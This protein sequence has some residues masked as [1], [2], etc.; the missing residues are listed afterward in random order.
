M[1]EGRRRFTARRNERG[2]AT[3]ELALV[4]PLAVLL[5]LVVV[6][7]GVIAVDLVLVHHAAREAARAAA[8]EPTTS[9]AREAAVGSSS[10]D[11]DRIVVEL[12]GGSETGDQTTATVVYRASTSVPLV[13]PLIPD[14]TLRASVTMRV[15]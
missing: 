5:A 10:L 8:V 6:Q 4:L 12:D 3:V 15:E 2:Q 9:A 1:G 13:G 7:L 11:R 14:V